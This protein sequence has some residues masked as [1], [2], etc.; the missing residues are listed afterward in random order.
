MVRSALVAGLCL[1]LA[2]IS[3]AAAQSVSEEPEPKQ[4]VPVAP[5]AGAGTEPKR[6][7]TIVIKPADMD[8]AR[9]VGSRAGPKSGVGEAAPRG[10]YSVQISAQ[11]SEEAAQS[12]YRALQQKFP[13]ILGG[14]EATL[15]RVDLQSQ[16]TWYRAGVGPFASAPAA[17]AF[18][19]RLKDA[20]GQCIVQPN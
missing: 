20:G 5:Q 10:T 14:R 15:R 9:A 1:G 17:Q 11:R 8:G 2:A 4:S 3:G 19:D 12:A 6:V 18:C 7:K 13:S 16:G